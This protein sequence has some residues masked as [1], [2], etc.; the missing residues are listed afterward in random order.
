[1]DSSTS[2]DAR[3][4]LHEYGNF[5]AIGKQNGQFIWTTV[6]FHSVPFEMISIKL[7]TDPIFWEYSAAP[8]Y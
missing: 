6:C 2:S 1:M 4:F 5:V 7:A 3:Q 8:K